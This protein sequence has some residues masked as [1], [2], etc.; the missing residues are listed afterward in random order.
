M[1]Y[2]LSNTHARTFQQMWLSRLGG[3][4]N[5]F[6]VLCVRRVCFIHEVEE[7]ARIDAIRNG[8]LNAFPPLGDAELKSLVSHLYHLKNE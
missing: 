1:K 3:L 7:L 8:G 5:N 4:T 2:Q 6:A